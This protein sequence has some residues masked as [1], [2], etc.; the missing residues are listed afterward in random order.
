MK[1]NLEALEQWYWRWMEGPWQVCEVCGKHYRRDGVRGMCEHAFAAYRERT[2]A[3][4]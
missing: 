1:L 4:P 3:R 2:G